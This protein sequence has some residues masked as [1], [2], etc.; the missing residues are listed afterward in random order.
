MALAARVSAYRTN[1]RLSPFA[2]P[3]WG[4][5]GSG[6]KIRYPSAQPS[7]SPAPSQPATSQ[8]P[9]NTYADRASSLIAGRDMPFNAAYDSKV[10]AINTGLQNTLA[11]YGNDEN[12]IRQT[13]GFDDTTDPFSRAR[14]LQRAYEQRQAGNTNSYAAAGQLYSGALN[15]QRANTLTDYQADENALRNQYTDLLNQLAQRRAQAGTDAQMDVADAGFDKLQASLAAPV[16]ANTAATSKEQAAMRFANGD[17][18]VLA[19]IL[20]LQAPQKK[21]R[22]KR[23]N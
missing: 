4:T 13:F 12:R 2:D 23:R 1:L 10:S 17:P 18:T 22:R 21:I 19:A 6:S 3:S 14:M 8:P 5:A 16:D 20:G 11:A 9:A 7:S 15:R